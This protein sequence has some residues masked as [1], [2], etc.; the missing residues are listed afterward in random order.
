MKRLL[1]GGLIA[2]AA[3]FLVGII[4]CLAGTLLGGGNMLR[5][6]WNQGYTNNW[7]WHLGRDGIGWGWFD[8][9]RDWDDDVLDWDDDE[10]DWYDDDRYDDWDG[11]SVQK[12]FDI[13]AI[14][15]IRIDMKKG[16][17]MIHEGSPNQ[18]TVTLE[19]QENEILYGV[20]DG[21][22]YIKSRKKGIFWRDDD[23]VSL[24]LPA[25]MHLQG[26]HA[27]I[28]A[29]DLESVPAITADAMTLEVGAG[30]IDL[31]HITA[32][33]LSMK[34]GAG[35]AELM[36]VDAQTLRA[37]CGMGDLDIR[38]RGGANDY[39]YEL[40]CGMGDID[41]NGSSYTSLGKGH[42]IQN[43]AA[44][45][46]VLRCGMGDISV[47]TGTPQ[48]TGT[49]NGGYLKYHHGEHLDHHD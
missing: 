23:E 31:D 28:G 26:F 20:Q 48:G 4:S 43:G 7:G 41:L 18:A 42:M 12:S 36:D 34:V 22:L 45:N 37:D 46:V 30:S 13:S 11:V 5:Q 24:E 1:R 17:L 25:G 29:C 16:S 33:E 39:N 6:L 14:Q 9:D 10:S 8:D 15:R 35:E 44:K 49:G 47:E 19:N 3:F 21:E 32:T 27:K 38:L 40:N 2:A